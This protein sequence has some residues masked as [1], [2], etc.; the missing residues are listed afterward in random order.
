MT[1]VFVGGRR[2]V[3]GGHHQPIEGPGR[4]VKDPPAGLADRVAVL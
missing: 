4:A 3:A 1:V 2:V